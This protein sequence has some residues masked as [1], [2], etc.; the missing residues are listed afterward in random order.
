MVLWAAIGQ[1]ITIGVFLYELTTDL[2]VL[3]T[4][5]PTTPLTIPPISIWFVVI[6]EILILIALIAVHVYCWISIPWTLQNQID[7]TQQLAETIE[8]KVNKGELITP[9]EF[10]PENVN[11]A[12]PQAALP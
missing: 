8:Q 5:P 6:F 3:P 4:T 12:K 7:Q 2:T 9:A 1:L 10:D 11:P